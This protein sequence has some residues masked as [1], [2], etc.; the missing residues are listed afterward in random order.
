MIQRIRLYSLF[1][2][3]YSLFFFITPLHA[4]DATPSA[5]PEPVIPAEGVDFIV[6]PPTLDFRTEPGAS[7]GA[8]IKIKNNNTQTEALRIDIFK[9]KANATGDAPELL[10]L[11]SEDEFINWLQFSETEFTIEPK[12]WKQIKVVFSPPENAAPGY[13]FAIAFN[14][15]KDVKIS[16]GQVAKGAA[17]VLC[18]VQV[19][20]S[21]VFHQVDL[22]NLSSNGFDFKTN[23]Y[24][25]EFLPVNFTTTLQ[26]S[27]NV[28]ERVVGNIF[29]D[30]VTGKKSD[31]GILEVNPDKSFILPQSTRSFKSSWTDGFPVWEEQKDASGNPILDKKGNPKQ[32]LKW[33]F[34]KL[35]SF[36]IGKYNATLTMAYNDGTRD[37]PLESH[38]SFWVIPWRILLALLILFILIIVGIKGSIQNLYEKAKKM[39]NKKSSRTTPPPIPTNT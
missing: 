8:T 4:Q 19:N 15:Q 24:I 7:V 30:W 39:Q 35:M 31:V 2:I 38:V 14:R 37:I 17:A 10:D 29:I 33:D 9:F 12:S 20:S 26:N 16:T 1:V 11:T 18:L 13:Y 25:Y 21:R 23:K 3:L 34:S 27:G 32:K 5:T 6:S 22:M 36:R 28:H